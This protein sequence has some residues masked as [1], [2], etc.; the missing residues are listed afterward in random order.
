MPKPQ[1][2]RLGKGLSVLLG[3]YA[4]TPETTGTSEFEHLPL[5]R[6]RP[7]PFQPR[8]AVERGKLS[9]LVASIR[10]N[11]LLQPLVVRPATEGWQIVAGERRWR[12]VTELGW[13]DVP[14]Y[15]READDQTMFVLALVENLQREDLSPVDEAHAYQR[16]I[17]Q[18]GLTQ[19]DV[20][21][22][23]G[24]DRSTVS[25][26]IRLLSLPEQV[27]EMLTAGE[28]S[29]GHARALL[30]VGDAER[31]IV[32]AR[33][34]VEQGLSVRAL[35]AR[36]RGPKPATGK[37]PRRRRS[38]GN[39]QGATEPYARRAEQALGR[40][41]GTAVRVTVVDKTHGQ[42]EIPFRDPEDFERIVEAIVGVGGIV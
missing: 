23:V 40:A 39:V 17:D 1:Q 13:T 16:L 8:R 38:T 25:N 22:Q 29:A 4:E 19:G 32:L 37:K 34:T 18:F 12:A 5:D 14:A 28:L 42:I 27:L 20:A 2:K 35:E 33:E 10:E 7:N 21:D 11:G 15:V 6:L 9:E 31:V 26:T 30:G 41:L 3:E 36:V 24:R